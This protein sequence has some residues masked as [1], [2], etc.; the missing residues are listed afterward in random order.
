MAHRIY[1]F[2]PGTKYNNWDE[3]IA[4][5]D[6]ITVEEFETYEEAVAAYE[7]RYDDPDVYGVE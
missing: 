7:D 3:V 1:T 2:K 4:H 5:G 6:I